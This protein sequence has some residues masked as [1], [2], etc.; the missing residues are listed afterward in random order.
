MNS[1]TRKAVLS[2][3]DAAA[4]RLKLLLGKQSDRDVAMAVKI[5]VR[6]RGCNG[7]SYTMDY[8]KEKGKLDEVVEE[9]GVKVIVDNKALMVLL[10][11]TMDY[12]EDDLR[13]E[14]VFVNPNEKGRC[15]CGESFSV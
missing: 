6:R 15:G 12:V 4:Q 10:G 13:A 3:T 9:K 5:G 7:L 14:F 1:R 8:A 11:T 2:I